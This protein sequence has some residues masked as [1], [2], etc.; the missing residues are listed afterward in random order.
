MVTFSGDEPVPA[1]AR[2]ARTRPLPAEQALGPYGQVGSLVLAT[3]R[4]LGAE[5]RGQPPGGSVLRRI[6]AGLAAP[7]AE[8]AALH[9]TETGLIDADAIAE[10]A[11]GQYPRQQFPAVVIGSPHGAAAHLAVALRVPWLPAAF[12]VTVQAAEPAEG[13]V[14]ALLSGGSLVAEAVLSSNPELSVRQ[15][16]DPATATPGTITLFLRWRALPAAYEEFLTEQLAS[17]ASILLVRDTSTAPAL[18]GPGRFGFQY[19]GPDDDLPSL[20][21]TW[22]HGE[23]AYG[24]NG[25][26]AEALR[27]FATGHGHP[28]RRIMFG[29][30]EALSAAV[31]D[32]YRRWLRSAGKT[33]NRLVIE[34]GRLI[35]PAQVVRAG[36]VPFWLPAPR[37]HTVAETAWWLAGSEPFTQIEVLIEP[38]GTSAPTLASL[39]QFEAVARFATRQGRVD[40]ATARA[41]PYGTISAR[42][43]SR[44]LK[45]HPYDLPVPPE[46]PTG[47]AVRW[48]ADSAETDDL[49]IC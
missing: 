13:G 48:L 3:A 32:V 14:P 20:P 43:A 35:D 22:V 4:G 47:T 18:V 24:V 2:A 16:H 17:G 46:L 7:V 1:G 40:T 15:V 23:T 37:R 25:A 19:G 33:G 36:L 28:L 11:T 9:P 6:A 41:Y 49:M 30:P 27:V 45:A 10:F 12:D 39:A 26:F 8:R 31:A 34:C 38:P 21:G 42:H 5:D 29:R 44:V